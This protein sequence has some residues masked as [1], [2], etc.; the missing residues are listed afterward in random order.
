MKNLIK[1]EELAILIFTFV[2]FSFVYKY[3]VLLYFLFFFLPDLSAVGY[4]I[5]NKVGGITYD[6]FHTRTFGISIF[7]LGLIFVSL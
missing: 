1:L 4:L 7:I 6:F 3:N 5:N 2:L